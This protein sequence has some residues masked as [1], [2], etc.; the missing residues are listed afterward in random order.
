MGFT[1]AEEVDVLEEWFA[2]SARP[3]TPTHIALWTVAP[4]DDGTGGT[5][6]TGGSYARVAVAANGTN[7]GSA[8]AGDPSTIENLLEIAFVEATGNWGTINAATYQD[9][10]TVGNM[11]FIFDIGTPKAI[12]SGDTAKFAAGSLLAR[13]G[14]PGDSF[15]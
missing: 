6:A 4:A 11:L 13:M 14:N 15:P 10:L 7:W 8:A 9:A 5:E 12:D 3:N 1:D 2:G